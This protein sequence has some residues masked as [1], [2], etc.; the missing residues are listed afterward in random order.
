MGDGLTDAAR[1]L[2]RQLAAQRGL[3]NALIYPVV[4]LVTV[5]AALLFVLGYV[6]PEFEPIFAGEEHRLPKMTRVVLTLSHLVTRQGAGIVVLPIT[7]MFLLWWIVRKNP[8]IGEA[9]AKM[10]LRLPVVRLIAQIDV[11]KT[12]G[13]MGALID[14]G[15][16][17]SESVQL[18]A[19]AA[20]SKRLREAMGKASRELREGASVSAALRRIDLIPE[21]TVS[22]IEVGEHTG[23]LGHASMRAAHLLETDSTF[24]IDRLIALLNPIAIAVLGLI[25]GFVI[26]GVMLGIMSINQMAVR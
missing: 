5:F 18:A 11:A 1:Y 7:G 3:V 8:T 26:A 21:A 10:A 14:N 22:I 24:R 13:V 15:V 20:S 19:Q 12:L 6:I 2:Q 4:V 16:E 25:V 17:V 23:T 9:M